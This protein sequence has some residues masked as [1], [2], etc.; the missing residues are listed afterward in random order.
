[1]LFIVPK[2]Q[3]SEIPSL[4]NLSNLRRISELATTKTIHAEALHDR[5]RRRIPFLTNNA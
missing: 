3:K 4:I 1:V 2:N 5:R